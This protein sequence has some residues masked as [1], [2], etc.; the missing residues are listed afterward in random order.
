[1]GGST[2]VRIGDDLLTGRARRERFHRH[3]HV[4]VVPLEKSQFPA[5]RAFLQR[6][7]SRSHRFRV[8][9]HLEG[10]VRNHHAHLLHARVLELTREQAGFRSS[11]ASAIASFSMYSSS[12]LYKN[13]YYPYYSIF[14]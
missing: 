11:T 9:P 8:L 4:D 10:F 12:L 3:L 13:Y 2:D 6:V 1:M 14:R 7:D 5:L